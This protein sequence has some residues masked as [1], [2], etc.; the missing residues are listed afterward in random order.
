[1]DY[2]IH[3]HN[4]SLGVLPSGLAIFSNLFSNFGSSR[5]CQREGKNPGKN[6]ME[7]AGDSYRHRRSFATGLR[8]TVP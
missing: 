4:V 1:V 2:F 6:P 3:M 5:F 8:M 7:A